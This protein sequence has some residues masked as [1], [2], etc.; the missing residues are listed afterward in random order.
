MPM[1]V[2]LPSVL[3]ISSLPPDW[4]TKPDTM[5]RP[6]PVPWSRVLVVKNGSVARLKTVSDIPTPLS[7]TVICAMPS[8]ALNASTSVPPSGMASLA[9]THKL[10]RTDSKPAPS[11]STDRAVGGACVSN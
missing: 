3:W 2:P 9:L 11:T 10:S 5:D 6:S 8:D 4:L 1:Q 7:Q